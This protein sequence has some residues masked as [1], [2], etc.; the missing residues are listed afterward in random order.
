MRFSKSPIR[1]AASVHIGTFRHPTDRVRTAF[2]R[3]RGQT[4]NHVQQRDA[5]LIS[6]HDHH[7]ALRNIEAKWLKLTVEQRVFWGKQDAIRYREQHAELSQHFKDEL[8]LLQEPQKALIN[9]LFEQK[10]QDQKRIQQGIIRNCDLL[11]AALKERTEK[12]MVLGN[13]NLC[14]ALERMVYLAKLEEKIPPTVGVQEGLDKLAQR[15]EFT[16]V[17]HKEVQARKLVVEDVMACLNHLYDKVCKRTKEMEDAMVVV[18][19]A[20]YTDNERAA[21]VVLLKLQDNWL[22]PLDWIEDMST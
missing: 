15:S 13:C 19:A 10:E 7:V 18:R 20:R 1:F 22:D 14:G 16:E 12:M 9:D 8:K 3:C 11:Y 17:L 21:L 5:P 4:T 2:D 6:M